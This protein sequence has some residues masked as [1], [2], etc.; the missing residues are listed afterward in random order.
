MESWEQY[1]LVFNYGC[2]KTIEP[3][4]RDGSN[5]RHW[6][7]SLRDVLL[8]NNMTHVIEKPL[9]FPPG[10]ESSAQDRDDYTE[11]SDHSTLVSE[12]ML[13]AMEPHLRNRLMHFN[14]Y[15][16][17]IVVTSLFRHQMRLMAFE[18]KREFYS[19]RMEENGN[20]YLHVM[21]MYELWRRLTT[22]LNGTLDDKV[23]IDVVLISLPASYNDIVAGFIRDRD[24]RVSFFDFAMWLR[25]QKVDSGAGEVID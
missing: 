18:C 11:E 9:R 7:Q 15:E 3:L 19:M 23:A 25:N 13:S 5:F 16:M 6:F 24:D 2:F 4:K 22:V 1:A 21:K 17:Y 10:P 14:A 12:M 8:N 20:I